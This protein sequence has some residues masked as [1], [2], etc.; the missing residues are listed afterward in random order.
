M[1]HRGKSPAAEGRLL[2][3]VVCP[4]AAYLQ[5]QVS[6]MDV[7]YSSVSRP[8]DCVLAAYSWFRTARQLPL[9]SEHCFATLVVWLDVYC[10]TGLGL[11]TAAGLPWD[12]RHMQ[13]QL[14][15]SGPVKLLAVSELY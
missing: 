9:L 5:Q 2:K 1:L 14:N 7:T 4:R 10:M 3:R 13:Q 11:R 6:L 15:S 12:N 8:F